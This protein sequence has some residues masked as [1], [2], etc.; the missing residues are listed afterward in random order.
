MP[1]A[2]HAQRRQRELAWLL[3]QVAGTKRNFHVRPG[4]SLPHD[5]EA[6]A[7]ALVTKLGELETMIRAAM[8]REAFARAARVDKRPKHLTDQDDDYSTDLLL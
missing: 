3:Y 4:N 2:S 1:R 6:R 5:I 8:A 7:K